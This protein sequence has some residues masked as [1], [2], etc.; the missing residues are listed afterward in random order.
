MID[1]TSHQAIIDP[2]VAAIRQLQARLDALTDAPSVSVSAAM[3]DEPAMATE[4]DDSGPRKGEPYTEEEDQRIREM[5]VAGKRYR[6]IADELGR[7]KDG[8]QGHVTG[9]YDLY[10]LVQGGH[11]AATEV[12]KLVALGV[13]NGMDEAKKDE[14]MRKIMDAGGALT[15]AAVA[16]RETLP[17][18][19]ARWG[20][21][22]KAGGA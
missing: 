19:K 8:V 22:C 3:P 2:D 18:A 11:Q 5:L 13:P 9:R 7:S 21:L 10:S 12:E 6:E 16:V 14:V 20:R 15:Q 17:A 4:Q 1:M